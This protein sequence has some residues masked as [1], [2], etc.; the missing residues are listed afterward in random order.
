MLHN[1]SRSISIKVLKIIHT[2]F[3]FV[4]TKVVTPI[5]GKI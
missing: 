4:K 3:V 1:K 2:F 5:L